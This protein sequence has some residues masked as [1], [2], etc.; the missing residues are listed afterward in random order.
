[1]KKLVIEV[2][3]LHSF[4]RFGDFFFFWVSNIL[5]GEEKR[6]K[7]NLCKVALVRFSLLMTGKFPVNFQE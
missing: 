4:F 1:M 3:T 7:L 5:V 6:R 2:S